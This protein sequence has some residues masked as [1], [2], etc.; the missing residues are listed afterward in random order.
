MKKK[1]ETVEV[2]LVKP[3]LSFWELA[4]KKFCDGYFME[5]PDFQDWGVEAG[6][7]VEVPYDPKKHGEVDDAEPG[8]P[9]NVESDVAKALR[10]ALRR[11]TK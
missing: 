8:Q 1:R 10:R 4:F 2:E 7:L 3:L 6:M 11:K 5:G 9:I